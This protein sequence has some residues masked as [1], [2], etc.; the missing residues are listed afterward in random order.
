VESGVT[1]LTVILYPPISRVR[2]R[3]NLMTAALV[4]T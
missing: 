3:E 4:A 1:A 2:L